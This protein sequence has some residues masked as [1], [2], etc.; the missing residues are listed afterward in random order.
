M[1]YWENPEIRRGYVA[2]SA[3]KI[4]TLEQMIARLRDDGADRE[5]LSEVNRHFHSLCGSGTTYGFP[6]V[7]EIARAGEDECRL[8]MT[9][10]QPPRK[11]DLDRWAAYMADLRGALASPRPP[12]EPAA[13]E[14]AAAAGLREPEPAA[15]FNVLLVDNDPDVRQSLSSYLKREGMLVRT[16]SGREVAFRTLQSW[17]PDGLVVE[18]DLI[19]GSGLELV[20]QVRRLP[21]AESLPILIISD[22]TS[23]IDK[24]E[25]VSCGADAFFDK[26]LDGEAVAA[27]LRFLMEKAK[28]E[29]PRILSVE[30]DADQAAYIRS[31]LETAGYKVQICADPTAFESELVSFNPDLVIMDIVLPHDIKGYDLVRYLRQDERYATLPVL[32]L[33]TQGQLQAKIETLKA[34]GDDLL[35]KPVLPGLLLSAVITKVERSRFLKSLLEKDGLTRLLTH[36]AFLERAR[37]VI[38][39]GSRRSDKSVV[40]VMID[41]DGFKAIND[42]YGHPVGDQVLA[43]LS[44]LFRRRLRQTDTLGRYGGDEFVILLNDLNADESVR[45][46]EK[47]LEEFRTTPHKS[48]QGEIFYV[49]FSAGIATLQRESMNLSRWIQAADQALYWAKQAGRKCVR[50]FTMGEEH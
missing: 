3:D 20:E 22:R 40:L 4:T 49:T 29:P 37:D 34:G 10:S 47:L 50:V 7:T 8:L 33:S 21:G 32:F 45:L 28:G 43:S 1:E 17:M 9:S 23:F 12:D 27:R 11:E 31:V 26:P 14:A 25:S 24:V 13:A 6:G 16:A 5:A 46:L 38:A 30:D 42:T 35:V 36:T 2:R 15:L 19:D 39:L 41:L 44:S 48:R 18:I